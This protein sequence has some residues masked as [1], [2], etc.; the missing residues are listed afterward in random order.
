MTW[1]SDAVFF[2]HQLI[3]NPTVSPESHVV[4]VAQ[5]LIIVLQGNIPTGNETAE[6]LQTIS[7]LF[8]KIILATNKAA[9]AKAN[10][11]RV[12]ATQAARQAP[13]LPRVEAPLPSVETPIPRVT[14]NLEV[15]HTQVD[16]TTQHKD[17]CILPIVTNLPVPRPIAQAP[18]TWSNAL[19]S[20]SI[21]N[22]ISQDKD[23]NP[24]LMRQT[25][26]S[27]SRSIMQEAM[28]S[29]V[30]MYKKQYILSA[31]LG[32]LNYTQTPKITG[33]TY[34][35]TPKQIA[36][37][38]LPMKWLCKKG[39][40]SAGSKPR[41]LGVLPPHCKPSHKSDLGTL[42]WKCDWMP[43]PG[44]TGARHQHQHNC[45]HQEKP[46][47][48]EQ[49]K[50]RDLQANHLPHETWKNEGTNKKCFLPKQ[51]NGRNKWAWPPSTSFY[52]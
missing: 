31:D 3:T 49:S 47:P 5:Q 36:Q 26:R 27:A 40:L 45:L 34:T 39:K 4:A 7:K 15:H 24:S 46:G 17:W 19:S 42:I 11:N 22:Y 41:T 50:G 25:T 35:V 12:C 6:A 13:H 20:E 33:T 38:K 52:L 14:K 2:K 10:C 37:R 8:T 9:K 1:I 18:A 21:P 23:D 44:N 48:T 29:C 16:T 51:K 28:L 32:I 30:D 43:C